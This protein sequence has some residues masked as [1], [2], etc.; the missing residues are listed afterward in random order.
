LSKLNPEVEISLICERLTG[1][2]VQA[3]EVLKYFTGIGE[4]LLNRYLIYDGM[5]MTFTTVK[6]RRNPNCPVCASVKQ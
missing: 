6:L 4:L 1:E 2:M 5:K 3:M